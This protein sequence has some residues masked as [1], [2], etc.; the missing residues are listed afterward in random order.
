MRLKNLLCLFSLLFCSVFFNGIAFGEMDRQKCGEAFFN[1][2]RYD[3]ILDLSGDTLYYLGQNV[4]KCLDLCKT[5]MNQTSA[6]MDYSY[7]YWKNTEN[8]IKQNT[9]LSVSIEPCNKMIKAI[10]NKVYK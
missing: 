5:A 9:T 1:L 10:R 2:S 4:K 6:I 7:D 3:N 8:H